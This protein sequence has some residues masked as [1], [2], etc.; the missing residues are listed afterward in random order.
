MDNIACFCKLVVIGNHKSGESRLVVNCNFLRFYV[1]IYKDEN[2]TV[3]IEYHQIAKFVYCHSVSTIVFILYPTVESIRQIQNALS[4]SPEDLRFLSVNKTSNRIFIM[5]D[6]NP[7]MNKLRNI[8]VDNLQYKLEEFDFHEAKY[9]LEDYKEFLPKILTN[10]NRKSS[11]AVL[12]K[13]HIILRYPPNI[14]RGCISIFSDDYLDLKPMTYLNDAIIDFYLKYFTL[15]KTSEDFQSRIHVFDS[16]FYKKLTTSEEK[17]PEEVES[18]EE[19][20][21]KMYQRVAKWDE[22][23]KLFEKDFIFVPINMN[24]HWFLAVI[25]YPY[26]QGRVLDRD[27]K[28]ELDPKIDK[29]SPII[30]SCILLFDSLGIERANVLKNLRNYLNQRYVV[31]NDGLKIFDFNSKVI[32]GCYVKA[33]RQPNYFD[34][35][36]FLLQYAESFYFNPIQDFRTPIK[37]LEKWF[38]QAVIDRKRESIKEIIEQMV[39]KYEPDNL[40]LPAI[41]FNS[42]TT[43]NYEIDVKQSSDTEV[44]EID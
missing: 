37:G 35:G 16:F 2:I 31:E 25:C 9:L 1:S 32:P 33:P 30:Q 43:R 29:H 19:K 39:E 36:I 20:N 44:F 38:E 27:T 13:S 4:L 42:N 40:P 26:L 7:E 28:E 24:E 11:V 15:E 22:K 3:T 21:W 23:V 18:K 17:N 10:D 41:D 6:N 5:L 14:S 34:C 12:D 8:L